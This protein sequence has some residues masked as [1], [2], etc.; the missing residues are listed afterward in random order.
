[1]NRRYFIRTLAGGAVAAL[2][3]VAAPKRS[4]E[5]EMGPGPTAPL[6][7]EADVES[8]MRR[9]GGR[10]DVKFFLGRSQPVGPPIWEDVSPPVES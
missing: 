3:M 10:L 6:I 8:Y 2:G 5:G 1:M 4:K 7:T 9:T